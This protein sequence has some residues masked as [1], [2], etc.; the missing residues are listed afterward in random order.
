VG[1]VRFV[2]TSEAKIFASPKLGDRNEYNIN[3]AS[4]NTIYISEYIDSF[5]PDAPI[6]IKVGETEA[7]VIRVEK[8]EDGTALY[9]SDEIY[10]AGG[11]VTV[12][13]T[14]DGSSVFSTLILGADAYG[15]TDMEDGI[16][17]IVKQKG[18]GN[19]PLN[20]RSSVGWKAFKCAKRLVEEYMIRVESV[21]E[22]SANAEAN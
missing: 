8:I 22:F 6:P 20:Q 13:G 16:E 15:V 5:T 17:N 9:L 14:A 4:G 3:S 2:E 19:D 10:D 11:T 12:I 21:S 18:Y 7:H 1:G